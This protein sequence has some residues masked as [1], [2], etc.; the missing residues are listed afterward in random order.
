MARID[1]ILISGENIRIIDYKL[2]NNQLL[3]EKYQKQLDFYQSILSQ[4]YP[5]FSIT[6]SLFFIKEMKLVDIN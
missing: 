5:E 6:K 1:R 2:S 4:I 3:F